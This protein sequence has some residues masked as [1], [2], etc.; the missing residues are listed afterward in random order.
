MI[1]YT[2]DP[3]DRLIA[4]DYSDGSYFYYEYVAVGNRLSEETTSGIT[5]YE[6]DEANWLIEVWGQGYA[7]Y[8]WDDNGILLDDNLYSYTYDHVNRLVGV[9]G[10]GL[11]ISYG[12]NG[13]GDRL[14]QTMNSIT[15]EYVLVLIVQEFGQIIVRY[16][17]LRSKPGQKL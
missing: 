4:A 1:T 3:L 16:I 13:L 11:S 15:T 17:L 6:Y 2:Y 12:Y 9:N 5:Y 10:E 8:T 14:Q 7:E